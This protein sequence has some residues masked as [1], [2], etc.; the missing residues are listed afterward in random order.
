MG[1]SPVDEWKPEE[2]VKYERETFRFHYPTGWAPATHQGDFDPDQRITIDSKGQSHIVIEILPDGS[3]L[4]PDRVMAGLL[5]AYDGPALEVLGRSDFDE[6]GLARGRG[7][8]L[9]GHI[10]GIEPG[11]IR[12]FV[13]TVG[14]RGLV[15][16]EYYFSDELPDA[17]PGFDL[18]MQSL[19]FK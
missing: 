19:A 1:S 7:V 16:T 15:V 3:L 11:G 6:W 10:L 9:K 12:L 18:I 4:D 17:M 8:H 13:A 5:Q 14:K 2:M